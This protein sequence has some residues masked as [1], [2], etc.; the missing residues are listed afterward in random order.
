MTKTILITGAAGG[1]GR[2]TV[3]LFAH[4]GWRVIGV[5]RNEFGED[6]PRSGLFI[7]S[8]ISRAED[9]ES[10]FGQAKAFSNTLNAL[11]NNAALQIA[12]PLVQTTVEEW[13]A[14]MAANLRSV[15]LGVKL[16]HPLLK[17]KGGAIVNVSSVHAVQTSANIAAYAASKGGLLALTRAMAIEFASDNIR[18]NAILPGAVDTPMLRAGLGR[19]HV[20]SGDVQERLD[21]LARKTVNGRVGTPEEIANAIYFLADNEQSSFMTGQAMIVDGGATA[22]LSTE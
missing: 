19:G 12:K 16:A 13:D 9:M 3:A 15:F 21:N 7:Q 10:I 1:I 11:V 6:F 20:G 8:D 14:V 4:K 22:R 17:A 2:A 18:V 5:D